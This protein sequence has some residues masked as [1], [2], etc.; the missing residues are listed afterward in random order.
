MSAARS[1]ADL[2]GEESGQLLPTS[3]HGGR[4]DLVGIGQIS[5][6]EVRVVDARGRSKRAPEFLC[7][8]QVATVILAAA[9]LGLRSAYQGAVGEDPTA[10]RALAPLLAAA[11]DCRSVKRVPGGR[12]R[13][14]RICVEGEG[15][16][17]RVEPQ[18]DPAVRLAPEDV[19]R[20]LIRQARLLHV[21]AE[22]PAASIRAV[23]LA[24]GLGVAT[25]LDL[26]EPGD[27]TLV[28]LHK[29]D[30]PIVSQGFA[31]KLSGGPATLALPELAAA[32]GRMAVITLGEEG[33]VAQLHGG[34]TV[35][36]CPAFSVEVRDTTGAGDAFRAGFIWALLQGLPAAAVLEAASAIAALNCGVLGAQGGLPMRQG[37]EAFLHSR[38]GDRT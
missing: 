37:L 15:G 26:D 6:D 25:T 19:D 9:R 30:F 12:T 17:R 5:V 7:G 2:E 16:D 13:T 38:K 24:R 36:H 28:L 32:A 21:D 14:A 18:R 20:G 31:T 35:L 22:D 3:S 10:D 23:E 27:E 4:L 33:A 29:T 8:G 11:V 34:Q 1:S